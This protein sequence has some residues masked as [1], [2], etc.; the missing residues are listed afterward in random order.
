MR[1]NLLYIIL[2][3]AVLLAAGISCTKDLKLT[4]E[5]AIGVNSFWKTPD[6]ATGGLY[7]MY[8][9]FRALAQH[10]LFLLGAA[11]SE[12]MGN[13]LQNA[14][15]RVKYFENFLD[16]TNADLNWQLPYQIVDYANLV[17]KFTPA[18]KFT[19]EEDKNNIL[20]Q[21]YAM[22][23]WVYFTMAKTWGDLPLLTEPSEGYDAETTFKP[24]TPVAQ[25]FDRIKKDIDTAL[26]LFADNSFPSGRAVWSKPATDVLK[27]DVYLWT[28]K[29]MNGGAQDLTTALNALNE[30]QTA[31]LML[32]DH[33]SDVFDYSNKGN[34]E[35]IMA[36]H[37][38]DLE[39]GN[40]YF[41]DMYITPNDIPP[42]LDQSTA[43]VVGV[44]GG[45]N[46]WAPTA[47]V[48]EQFT[49]D[50]QRKAATYADIYSHIGGGS[51]F[52]TSVV[53]KGNG[54][55]K[56][57]VREFLDDVIIYRYSDLL[58]M[59]A[60]ALNAL[61]QD[62]SAEMNQIRKRAYG[63]HYPDHIFVSGTK[64]QNDDAI[65]KERLLEL[66]FEG[67][68][69]W[70]LVRFGKAFDLVPSLKGREADDYLLLWPVTQQTITLNPKITQTPGY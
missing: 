41:A 42:T 15:F 38:E 52:V 57:G 46:W 49:D 44:G 22:R 60:E 26:V 39:A 62:P 68:R 54:F 16:A 28:A 6:D 21:A 67:K 23:A 24:R 33:F 59:K 25:I 13:G 27:G 20:A 34:K 51:S 10:N 11:R 14:D 63:T 1:K 18:I 48:R 7:G 50:D 61:G 37:F 35:I 3:S 5:S 45:F 56:A 66:A 31:D 17:I 65:L 58:L 19:K 9:K 64:A 47:L 4:P 29:R 40:N 55:I 36:A 70:D 8:D 12:L 30:A 53:V 69:W 2:I 43:A 32:L